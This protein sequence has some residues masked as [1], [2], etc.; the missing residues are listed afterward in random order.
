M[1][2]NHTD[3]FLSH[4]KKEAPAF[5]KQISDTADR[6]PGLF[7]ELAEPMLAWACKAIGPQWLETLTRGYTTFVVGVNRSQA[8]YERD[9]RYKHSS[10]AEVHSQ[11]YADPRFMNDYHWGVYVTTFAWE[12]HLHIYEFYRDQFLGRLRRS[13]SAGKIIDLGCGSGIWSMLALARLESWK[14]TLVDISPTTLAL[15]RRTVQCTG[16][17]DRVDAHQADAMS[18]RDGAPYDAGISCF[19]L[20][21]LESPGQLLASLAKSLGERRFAFVTAA[22]TAAEIDHIFEF[23]RESEVVAL[24]EQAGFRVV[25][26]FSSAPRSVAPSATFLPRSIALVLEKRVGEFW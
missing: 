1:S 13:A 6:N 4:I 15:T 23:R 5:A 25:A 2:F 14:S 10:Y 19:L 24:A 26:M 3:A 18:F 12:H 17:A 11:T 16:L 21:H 22:L 7:G 8:E 9:R 20:E